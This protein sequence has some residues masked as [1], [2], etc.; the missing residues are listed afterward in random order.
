VKHH[1][2]LHSLKRKFLLRRFSIHFISRVRFDEGI[3]AAFG[4]AFYFLTDSGLGTA[5]L[6]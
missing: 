2:A 1:F 3:S 6:A 4:M 5:D